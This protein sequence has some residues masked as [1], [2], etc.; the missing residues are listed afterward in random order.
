MSTNMDERDARLQAQAE[1]AER[2]GLGAS[3]NAGVDR[4]R[5][6]LRALRQP[7][8]AQLPAGF[9]AQV[10]ARVAH[11]EERTAFEDW[12]VSVALLALG[13]TGLFYLQPVMATVLA[14]V[15]VSLPPV[16]WHLLAAAAA[17]VAV[18]WL[19]DRGASRWKQ[20]HAH[21]A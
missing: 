2:A 9:A 4:Y 13:V 10:A 1:A 16:P 20:D 21:H 6:V 15:H 5:L 11:P 14:G 3:G 12:L 8:E 17:A 19:V 7:L 18:A